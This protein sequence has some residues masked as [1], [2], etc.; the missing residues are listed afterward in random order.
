MYEKWH[1]ETSKN[2]QCIW[3]CKQIFK[4]FTFKHSKWTL[5]SE[6]PLK[7]LTMLAYLC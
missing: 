6:T 3:R 5:K 1:A 2:T 4:R 7:Y